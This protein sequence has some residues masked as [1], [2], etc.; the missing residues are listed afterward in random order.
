MKFV[1]TFWSKNKVFILGL[2]SSLALALNEF[3]SKPHEDQSMKVYLIAALMAVLSYVAKEWRG[4][5][6]TIVGIIGT[7]AS[8][9]LSLQT[10]GTFTW[11]QFLMSAIAAILAAVAPPPKPSTYE[12]SENIVRAKE[13]PPIDQVADN[14]SVPVGGLKT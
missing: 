2:A 1:E 13:I 11:N 3:L 12:H 4:K 7:L 10:T 8:V 5:G 6:V 14:T 9:Y